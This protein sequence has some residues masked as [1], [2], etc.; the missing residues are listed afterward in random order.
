MNFHV[1]SLCFSSNTCLKTS[2]PVSILLSEKPRPPFPPAITLPRLITPRLSP[3]LPVTGMRGN[4]LRGKKF[5]L[6]MISFVSYPLLSI[7]KKRQ[8][9]Q[10]QENG[11][12]LST[13]RFLGLTCSYQVS[14][15]L[16]FP[17]KLIK[18]LST[19]LPCRLAAPQSRNCCVL[20][21]AIA[22]HYGEKKSV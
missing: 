1:V 20:Y 18:V 17:L 12:S 2:S 11:L 19:L 3:R 5:C 22:A 13:H 6:R 21:S 10:K 16:M 8:K 4:N 7:P 15:G 14:L 9:R